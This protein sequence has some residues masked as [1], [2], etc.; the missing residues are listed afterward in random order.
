MKMLIEITI[1]FHQ[2][3][4]RKG[5][6]L[7]RSL[8]GINRWDIHRIIVRFILSKSLLDLG[9]VLAEKLGELINIPLLSKDLQEAHLEPTLGLRNEVDQFAHSTI[10]V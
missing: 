10:L 1:I 8:E 9:L 4:G 2:F 3:G 5:S 6:T 7:I